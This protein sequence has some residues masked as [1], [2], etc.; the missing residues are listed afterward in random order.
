MSATGPSREQP[1]Q[2]PAGAGA[3]AVGTAPAPSPAA[4]RAARLTA[5]NMAKSLLPLV[6]IV[7]VVVG[8]YRWQQDDVN[9]VRT[10]DPSSTVR[11]AASHAAY[12]L[13]VPSGLPKGYRPT[14]VRTNAEQA[15]RGA[16][17]TL[18]IGYVTPSG[19]YAGFAESDDVDA[20]AVTGLLAGAAAKGT[21]EVDGAAWT[22]SAT[23]RGETVLWQ[24]SGSLTV[25]VSGSAS[26]RELETVVGSLR[27]YSG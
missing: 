5:A 9:P 19:Q 8:W 26:E 1:D 24:R 7:L 27:A 15:G 4:Q 3:P 11:L 23:R 18:Q 20:D 16:P 14:S 25:L 12:Q 21:V 2:P 22:R 13:V 17:V 10:V 6:V